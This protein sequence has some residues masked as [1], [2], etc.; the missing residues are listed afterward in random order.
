MMLA[1]TMVS[2]PAAALSHSDRGPIDRSH[3]ERGYVERG[4]VEREAGRRGPASFADL[5][6]RVMPAVVNISVSRSAPARPGASPRNTL[7]PAPPLPPEGPLRDMFEEL[8]RQSPQGQR[9]QVPGQGQS[10]PRP[11]MPASSVGS[12]FIIDASGIVVTNNHVIGD[13][14]DIYVVLADGERLKATVLGRDPR[15]DLAVLKV[16]SENDLPFVKLGDS[17]DTRIGDWVIAIGNPFGL[18]ASVSAGIVSARGRNIASGP[19]DNFLQTDAAINRGNSGGPLF[20]EDGVVIGIN[21]AIV[22]PSGG[23]VG[24]GFSIPSETASPVIAQLQEFGRTR[25]GWLGVRIQGIDD[26]MARA[27]RLENAKGALVSGLDPEGPATGS[28]L[29]PGDVIVKF[30]GKDIDTSRDLPRAVADTPAGKT[31]TIEVFRRG[32]PLSFEIEIGLVQEDEAER[33]AEVATQDPVID[34]EEVEITNERFPELGLVLRNIDEA[35]RLEQGLSPETEG[36]FVEEVVPGSPAARLNIAA[37]M[38]VL[39][40]D[41]VSVHSTEDVATLVDAANDVS[42]VVLALIATKDGRQIYVAIERE[43]GVD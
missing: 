4:H 39:E 11:P 32:V 30:D 1:G 37:G 13:G 38:I 8:L 25:R 43:D 40:I 28:G 3:R 29:R 27:L 22:S 16:E 42:G 24:I 10:Q 9:G 17:R 21:T 12:G 15:I 23:S 36:V 20:N 26:T 19:Y 34:E 31:V 2:F 18:G 7:P 5:V 41:G 14:G 33:V 6:E 35:L